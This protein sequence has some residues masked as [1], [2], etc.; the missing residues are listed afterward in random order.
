MSEI[1][2]S[3]RVLVAY[4]ASLLF[5]KGHLAANN[6]TTA[7]VDISKGV[8]HV[9]LAFS[10]EE[11]KELRKRVED[12]E[13]SNL[14]LMRQMAQLQAGYDEMQAKYVELTTEVGRIR[15]MP[16]SAPCPAA[17]YIE[18]SPSVTSRRYPFKDDSRGILALCG[19][20][21]SRKFLIESKKKF[22]R[23]VVVT[24]DETG[25]VDFPNTGFSVKPDRRLSKKGSWQDS[26]RQLLR[27]FPKVELFTRM[28]G[29]W[30]YL[31][32]YAV[33]RDTMSLEDVRALP[34]ETRRALVTQS[35]HK[36][37]R[38]QLQAMFEAGEM[39]G[40]KFTLNRV[41]YND[42]LVAILLHALQDSQQ[43]PVELITANSDGGS[44]DED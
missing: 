42:V 24:Q 35:C 20:S 32:T 38:T 21:R 7:H 25:W 26:N 27:R 12:V 4:Y 11:V 14:A 13:K 19:E 39:S 31:G 1:A 5:I 10:C 29:S 17:S 41:A 44:D 8:E 34:D 3:S 30:F 23:N 33:I 28:E 9:V 40:T 15:G 36:S 6:M 22:G 18:S 2:P 37:H 43:L 16:R